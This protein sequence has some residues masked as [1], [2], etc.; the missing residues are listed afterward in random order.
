MPFNYGKCRYGVSCTNASCTGVHPAERVVPVA[1]NANACSWKAKCTNPSCTMEHPIGRVIP[2]APLA[3][4]QQPI[5]QC[6]AGA[7]CTYGDKCTFAHPEVAATEL[8]VLK[9][10]NA[11]LKAQ[12]A[13]AQVSEP[14]VSEQQV[15]VSKPKPFKFTAS[16]PVFVPQIAELNNAQQPQYTFCSCGALLTAGVECTFCIKSGYCADDRSDDY[17]DSDDGEDSDDCEDPEQDEVEAYLSSMETVV[18]APVIRPTL[19][20]TF[21]TN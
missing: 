16:V 10:E 13:K 4:N 5:K 1:K 12:V 3:K 18:V 8:E 11:R 7:K 19:K 15:S 9:A 6:R 17:E 2:V 14:Q 21:G 20:F